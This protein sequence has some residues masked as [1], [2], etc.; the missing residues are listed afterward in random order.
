MQMF[1]PATCSLIQTK[2]LYSGYFPLCPTCCTCER[3]DCIHIWYNVTGQHAKQKGFSQCVGTCD[4]NKPI[5]HC[6]TTEGYCAISYTRRAKDQ[7]TNCLDWKRQQELRFICSNRILVVD[8]LHWGSFQKY[9]T[10]NLTLHE[11]RISYLMA[12]GKHAVQSSCT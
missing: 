11:R 2:S 10:K 4:Y 8:L 6:T 5:C 9:S 7:N 1:F 3:L 12:C